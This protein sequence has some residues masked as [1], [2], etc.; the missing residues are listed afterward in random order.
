[1]IALHSITKELGRGKHRKVV[2]NRI[3]LYLPPRTRIVILGQKG[4]GKSTLLQ[5]IHGGRYPTSGWV[6]RRGS[7]CSVNGLVQIK[8]PSTPYQFATRLAHLYR[9]G[10]DE[11]L[12]FVADFADFRDLMNAPIKSIPKPML[13]RLSYALAYGIPFDFYLFDGNVGGAK[14]RFGERCRAAFEMRCRDRGVILTTAIPKIAEGFDGRAAILHE[15]HLHLF[16]SVVEALAAYKTL[17]PPMVEEK[18]SATDGNLEEE[19][20]DN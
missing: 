1:M 2:L 10:A 6:E 8:G 20:D 17:P 13:S 18:H 16:P 3:S 4:T 19:H 14:D 15:G 5:I 9:V 7:V 11:L 12:Q